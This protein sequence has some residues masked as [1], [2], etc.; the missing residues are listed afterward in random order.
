MDSPS[1]AL[2][3]QERMKRPYKLDAP[4]SVYRRALE[5]LQAIGTS[6][7]VEWEPR[8]V[9][10]MVWKAQIERDARLESAGSSEGMLGPLTDLYR[11]EL[12]VEETGLTEDE[13]LRL[14]AL[15]MALKE[16]GG[17]PDAIAAETRAEAAESAIPEEPPGVRRRLTSEFQPGTG[18]SRDGKKTSTSASRT[19]AGEPAAGP[20]SSRP[21]AAGISLDEIGALMDER[22]AAQ[23]RGPSS[24]SDDT[25]VQLLMA[26][27][28]ILK[29]NIQKPN[30]K[31]STIKVEPK[32][33]WPSISEN[34]VGKEFLEFFKEFEKVCNLCNNGTGMNHNEMCVA[35]SNCVKGTRKKLWEYIERT[36]EDR[37]DLGESNDENHY[38]FHA[39]LYQ[40]FKQK[41]VQ[42]SE[43][44][45]QK[46]M[47]VKNA[48]DSLYMGKTSC[49]DFETAWREC[50]EDMKTVGMEKN[51]QDKYL[52]YLSKVGATRSL[53]IR[54]DRRARPDASGGE[55]VRYPNS[56]EEGHAVL[57]EAERLR[58]AT[59][60]LSS[61]GARYG[62]PKGGGNCGGQ[63]GKGKTKGGSKGG[64]GPGKR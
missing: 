52:D 14:D 48:Y 1:A 37:G 46:V 53:Q 20:P 62:T 31:A 11:I 50:F 19:S 64:K 9:D 12:A 40:E 27:T 15:V 41:L 36:Y 7:G 25:M 21:V 10:K 61:G 3:V 32:V 18:K 22:I 59:L 57:E 39:K 58:S 28:E 5:R 54:S 17:D 45:I 23:R 13:Q 6:L 60:A 51:R 35:L 63:F 26:Q 2:R 29:N 43:T 56:W 30:K 33:T 16:A 38:A 55:T 24:S 34:T 49:L 44:G 47:R 42:S 8:I 4:L